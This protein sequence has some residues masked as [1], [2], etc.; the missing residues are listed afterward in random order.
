VINGTLKPGLE[1]NL[2][3]LRIPDVSGLSQKQAAREYLNAGFMPHPWRVTHGTKASCYSGFSFDSITETHEDIS[4]WRQSWRC[5]LVVS[6]SSGLIAIDVDD[7]EEFKK[8]DLFSSFPSTAWQKTGREGG[9]YHLLFDARLLPKS[10][11]PRQGNIPG[12]Q[13]KSRGFIAVE[14][15]IHPSGRA[16][17]WGSRTVAPIGSLGSLLH[18]YRG[19]ANGHESSGL[20]LARLLRTGIEPGVQDDTVTSLIMKMRRDGLSRE[21]TSLVCMAILKNSRTGVDALGNRSLKGEWT[22]DSLEPKIDSADRRIREDEE[23]LA[24]IDSAVPMIAAEEEF[25]ESRSVL[26][27]VRTWARAKRVGPWAVLGGCL[28]QAV[29]HVSPAFVLPSLVGGHGTLNMLIAITGKSGAGKSSAR[30]VASSAFNWK[31]DEFQGIP[32]QIPEWTLGSGEGI[33]KNFGYMTK[34]KEG[35]GYE[36]CRDAYSVLI[37]ADEIDNYRA[38]SSRSGST[39]ST[40]I[41]QLY[42]G[43]DLGFANADP[44]KRAIIR[45][46]TYRA[47]L[48]AGVQPGQGATILHDVESGFAQRWL[49]LPASDPWAPD[50]API[51]PL[52]LSWSAPGSCGDAFVEDDDGFVVMDV[53]AAVRNETDLFRLDGLRET[54]R[55]D[56]D[57]HAMLTRLKVAAGLALLDGSDSVRGSD[58]ELSLVV[59]K[60][61]DKCRA[62]VARRLATVAS[63][64]NVSRGK[65][66]GV[67]AAVAAE[68]AVG[69][70]VG[71]V[72]TRILKLIPS[73]EWISSSQLRNQKV[74]SRDRRM[75]A[76]AMSRLVS[77]GLVRERHVTH[78][79]GEKGVQ[80]QRK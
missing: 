1:A 37:T 11:W 23:E 14:P 18:E 5:A 57:A 22:F 19:H 53:C 67:R 64:E 46:G 76:E 3:P 4:S 34:R 62:T 26:S 32:D 35:S 45:H 69:H 58:W 55:N 77:D 43:E 25:W 63:E 74:A 20:D 47:C 54:G 15:S 2:L 21:V 40:Q 10:E 49:W 65:A 27:H 33:V 66:E 44:T 50:S 51:C 41:R 60:V 30:A 36:L 73:G 42:T 56:L 7:L 12:G 75:F 48:I 38:Q 29:C 13:I 31:G 6:R 52:P 59:M 39:L 24:G 28:A 68:A 16:Y 71:R 78:V 70:A 72:A 17:V 9:G 8:W 80:F 61:S 79:N